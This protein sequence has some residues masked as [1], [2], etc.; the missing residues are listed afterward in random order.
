M[1]PVV[2]GDEVRML[3][4]LSRRVKKQ[5]MDKGIGKRFSW[6]MSVFS[7]QNLFYRLN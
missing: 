5:T 6:D 3:P 7:L 2:P 1:Y 4:G